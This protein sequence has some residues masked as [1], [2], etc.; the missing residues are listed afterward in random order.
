MVNIGFLVFV[1]L[2]N[3]EKNI[4]LDTHFLEQWN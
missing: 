1:C 3:T 2:G 4:S